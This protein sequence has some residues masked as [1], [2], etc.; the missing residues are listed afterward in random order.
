MSRLAI[1]SLIM[2]GSVFISSVS[3]IMLKKSAG[4]KYES[5]LKEYLNP[6]V[7]TAYILFFG[8]TFITMY[9]LKV[10]PLSMSPILESTGYVFVSVLSYIFLREKLNRRQL[11]GM[12]AIICGVI[13]YSL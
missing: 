6:V 5:K 4:K 10:V 8:C 12:V 3:Q 1:Y 7:M 11:L 13:V 2:L 9:A